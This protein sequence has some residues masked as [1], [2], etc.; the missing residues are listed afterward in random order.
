MVLNGKNT[1]SLRGFILHHS[2]P[3]HVSVWATRTSKMVISGSYE[4]AHQLRTASRIWGR[5]W[6]ICGPE[7]VLGLFCARCYLHSSPTA[8]NQRQAAGKWFSF[9][10]SR[11][12]GQKNPHQL[13][14]S[15]LDW[16]IKSWKL[17]VTFNVGLPISSGNCCCSKGPN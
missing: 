7:W 14:A 4:F 3:C 8:G 15:T 1:H 5:F 6:L 2:M 12:S 10:P 13:P 11:K 17:G 9:L 16:G